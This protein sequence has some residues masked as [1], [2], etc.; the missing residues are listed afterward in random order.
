[1]TDEFRIDEVKSTT[2]SGGNTVRYYLALK[3][4]DMRIL[5]LE[6]LVKLSVFL[7]KYVEENIRPLMK[8]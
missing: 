2:S 3:D 5:S 6:D 7:N 4:D 8:S 1:M